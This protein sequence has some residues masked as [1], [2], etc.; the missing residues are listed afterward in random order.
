MH[1]FEELVDHGLQELPMRFQEPRILT[2]NVHNV[3]R[4]YCLVVLALLHFGES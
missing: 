3:R 4:D 1:K 2:D